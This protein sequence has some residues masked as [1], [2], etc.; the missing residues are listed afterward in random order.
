MDKDSTIKNLAELVKHLAHELTVLKAEMQKKSPSYTEKLF[1]GFLLDARKRYIRDIQSLRNQSTHNKSKTKLVYSKSFGNSTSIIENKDHEFA[2]NHT[3]VHLK[4]NSI[5]TWIP[6][7]ACSNFRYSLAVSNGAIAGER[8][9]N[10]IHKN[11]TSFA[12]TNKELL[13]ADYAF[14]ALRNPFK[15][16]LS[17]YCDKLCNTNVNE[18]DTSY[19]TAK[20]TL[21]TSESTTFAEFVEALWKDPSLKKKNKHIRDQ[22]DFLVYQNYTEYFSLEKYEYMS[23]RLRDSIGLKLE[24][25]RPFN[26]VITTYKCSNCKELNYDTPAKTIGEALAKL[27]K[28]ITTNMYNPQLIQKVGALYFEDIL[29]YIKTVSGEDEMLYWVSNMF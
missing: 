28:P 23:S 27:K 12:A 8:Q 20:A 5:C 22:C 16:L 3:I 11:N 19:D 6:K 1:Q 15:R 25:A 13:K 21:G 24:D 2:R 4:S 29:L 14:V 26:S 18:N 7:N 10:W 9:I 17:F